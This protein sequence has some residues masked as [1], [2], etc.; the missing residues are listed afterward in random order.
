MIE[1]C[2]GGA[3]GAPGLVGGGCGAGGGQDDATGCGAKGGKGGLD[4]GTYQR[5][6]W[7]SGSE[8]CSRQG[9]GMKPQPWCSWRLQAGPQ[10]SHNVAIS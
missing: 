10:N 8:E 5:L 1:S 7:K 2:F 9:L 3:V 6:K 4:L